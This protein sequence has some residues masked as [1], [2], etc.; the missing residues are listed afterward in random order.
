[1]PR[2]AS[3]FVFSG[4]L[5]VMG[6]MYGLLFLPENVYSWLID[7]ERPVE[8]IGALAMLTA[9]VFFFLSFRRARALGEGDR[10]A[11][12][13]RIALL[14]LAIAFLVGFGE[15]I[16][17]GQRLLGVETPS[18]IRQASSQDEL[19][20]H[21]L[22]FFSGKLLD[23]DHL[24]QLFW[25]GFGVLIP[26]AVA[27]F[28]PARTFFPRYIPIVP[29]VLSAALVANQLMHYTAKA[30]FDGRYVNAAFPLSHSLFETKETIV[31]I[32]F[33]LAAFEFYRRLAGEPSD[34]T[35][36][37]APDDVAAE[38]PV[39]T[40]PEGRFERERGDAGQREAEKDLTRA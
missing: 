22:E 8:G 25:F 32:V 37:G 30:Y 6:A 11:R 39:G 27:L 17:W 19:N 26:V 14:L 29:L 2:R 23:P 3:F 7:E 13:R 4:L 10:G 12:V 28:R 20:L 34:K 38:A 1:V 5:V 36:A 35:S 31:A 18:E 16:S 24:F 15:E 21:N 40:R 33:A 9:S